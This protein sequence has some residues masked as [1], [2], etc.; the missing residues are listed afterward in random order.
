MSASVSWEEKNYYELLGIARE[1]SVDDI[2][3][4]YRD[5]SRIFHP[6]SNFYSDIAPEPMSPKHLEIFRRITHAYETL[7]DDKA[8]A[9]YD[10]LLT[11]GTLPEWEDVAELKAAQFKAAPPS[12]VFGRSYAPPSSF[13]SVVPQPGSQPSRTVTEADY[14]RPVSAAFKRRTTSLNLRKILRRML[15]RK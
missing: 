9:E 7:C 6:D 1:A 3:R 13:S 10:T 4:A 8:R 5:M 12:S 2:K 14:L 11:Q 15:G